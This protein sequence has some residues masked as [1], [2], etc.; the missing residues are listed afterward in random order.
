MREGRFEF[1]PRSVLADLPL[2]QT[3]LETL[4]PLFWQHRGGFFA[5]HCHCH[6]DGCNDWTLEEIQGVSLFDRTHRRP[7][8]T[9]I[10]RVLVDQARVILAG[11]DRSKRLRAERDRG[12]SPF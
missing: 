5:A 11:A 12:S 7:A 3:D 1:F 10:G 6:P 4:W 2:P 8:L 9:P